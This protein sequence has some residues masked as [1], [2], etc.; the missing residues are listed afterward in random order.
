MTCESLQAWLELDFPNLNE[1]LG[2]RALRDVFHD[3]L[4]VSLKLV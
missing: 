2:V 3:L 4:R 1:R